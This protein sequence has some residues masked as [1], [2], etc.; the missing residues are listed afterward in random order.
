MTDQ[1]GLS[2]NAPHAQSEDLLDRVDLLFERLG[3]FLVPCRAWGRRPGRSCRCRRG[4][5]LGARVPL[6]AARLFRGFSGAS[7]AF[8][9]RQP[10]APLPAPSSPASLPCVPFAGFGTAAFRRLGGGLL[11]LSP[12]TRRQCAERS[13]NEEPDAS[14]LHRCLFRFPQ[15]RR[16]TRYNR[17]ARTSPATIQKL[18]NSPSP[19]ARGTISRGLFSRST[20][21]IASS[22]GLTPRWPRSPGQAGL[23]RSHSAREIAQV[24]GALAQTRRS[25]PGASACR[26]CPE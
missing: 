19:S 2:S 3:R 24:V 8:G 18:E 16:T 12:G 20:T 7:F 26:R 25:G 4:L 6:V 15:Q 13:R 5:R 14:L 11:A 10:S 17:T 1:Y 21:K 23:P 22:C 9:A